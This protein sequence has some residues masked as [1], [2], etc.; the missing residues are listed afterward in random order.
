MWRNVLCAVFVLAFSFG[1][2]FA[3]DIKGRITKIDG[4]KVYVMTKDAKEAK[5]YELSKDVK[6]YMIK[7]KGGEKEEV[8]DGLKAK[9]LEN[10]D[11]EKG[12]GALLTVDGDKV[13]SIVIFG[14]KKKN[15]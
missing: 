6:V 14:G 7:M 10:I 15:N 8:K 2:V 3:D 13:T 1:L 4:G 9:A 11:P 5:A 12:R